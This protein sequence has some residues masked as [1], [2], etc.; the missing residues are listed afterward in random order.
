MRPFARCL[1]HDSARAPQ[2]L[3]LVPCQFFYL[4][5][6]TV[7]IKP[8]C[9]N[10][11]TAN[12]L[13]IWSVYRS[14]GSFPSLP[15][16]KC[17]LIHNILHLLKCRSLPAVKLYLLGI[18][19]LLPGFRVDALTVRYSPR[20]VLRLYLGSLASALG[21]SPC[22]MLEK[23]G[24]EPPNFAFTISGGTIATRLLFRH[25]SMLPVSPGCQ[26][27]FHFAGVAR[28]RLCGPCQAVCYDD[29][30]CRPVS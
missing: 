19:F 11:K 25:F 23:E 15:M 12:R 20:E 28:F 26:A 8:F 6:F 27:T 30:L 3:T 21:L 22:R 17:F 13:S 24:F 9:S 10:W 5:I 16:I 7:D 14:S 4:L 29:S 1:S 2:V 18:R